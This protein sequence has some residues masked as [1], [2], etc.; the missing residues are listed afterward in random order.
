M[1]LRT[2]TDS[3][4]ANALGRE[5]IRRSRNVISESDKLVGSS[6][7]ASSREPEVDEYYGTA[8]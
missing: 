5:L 4:D 7:K 6:M 3:D 8:P 1:R 2:N